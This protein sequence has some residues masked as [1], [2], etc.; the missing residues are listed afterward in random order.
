MP[1]YESGIIRLWKYLA[2]STG[3]N[4]HALRRKLT[5]GN[6]VAPKGLHLKQMILLF[7]VLTILV[8]VATKHVNPG[9][10]RVT[11]STTKSKDL[12]NK[13]ALMKTLNLEG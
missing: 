10:L 11:K 2:S 4:L 9:D 3:R 8:A 6:Q 7:Y 1:E 5:I 12:V 13:W